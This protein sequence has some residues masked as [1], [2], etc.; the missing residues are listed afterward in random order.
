MGPWSTI[1]V[2]LLNVSLICFLSMRSVCMKAEI[3]SPKTSL[4]QV[5]RKQVLFLTKTSLLAYWQL[6]WK[7]RK[8]KSQV[9]DF[10]TD[11]LH[12]S[13]PESDGLDLYEICSQEHSF[14]SDIN[15]YL[16]MHS[17]KIIISA[18]PSVFCRNYDTSRLFHSQLSQ[19]PKHI[20]YC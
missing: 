5:G 6:R 14:M 4:L 2:K 7:K 19:T 3:S 9:W 11:Y 20:I 16:Y 18:A 10:Y 13:F 8:K 12:F 1:E 17:F 15:F